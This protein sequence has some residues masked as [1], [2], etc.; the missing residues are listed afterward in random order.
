MLM[1]SAI[2]RS[3]RSS[4]RSVQIPGAPVVALEP[5]GNDR[6]LVDGGG[7][8]LRTAVDRVLLEPVRKRAVLAPDPR[9]PAEDVVAG[10][11]VSQP[12]QRVADPD[13]LAGPAVGA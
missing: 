6:G 7:L 11:R 9:Q 12:R 13:G 10:L 5:P 8:P 2:E 4:G 1:S 3:I